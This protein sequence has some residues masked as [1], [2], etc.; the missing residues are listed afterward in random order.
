MHLKLKPLRIRDANAIY[1]QLTGGYDI[2]AKLESLHIILHS[3]LAK[4][5]NLPV[6]RLLRWRWAAAGT[7]LRSFQLVQDYRAPALD[8]SMNAKPDLKRLGGQG[9]N[10]YVGMSRPDAADRVLPSYE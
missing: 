1:P 4:S 2:L 9:V 6:I 8:R 10:L 7:R 5:Y 3:R